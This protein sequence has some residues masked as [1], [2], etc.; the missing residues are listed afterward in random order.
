VSSSEE[1]VLGTVL[2]RHRA[3]T[4]PEREVG[5]R[6]LSAPERL[7]VVGVAAAAA[8]LVWPT[9]TRAT[10]V[11]LPCPLR[12]VTGVPCPL[13][14]MTTATVAL[15]RGDLASALSA[16]PFVV[17]LAALVAAA[18]AALVLRSLGLLRPPEPWGRTVVTRLSLVALAAAAASEAWQLHR[19]GW[20]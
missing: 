8:A 4:R 5:A 2:H 18:V 20:F 17:V 1:P 15:V 14:G 6:T 16:N 12:W 3:W 10:G 13:C 9:F 11:S 19:L 7:G